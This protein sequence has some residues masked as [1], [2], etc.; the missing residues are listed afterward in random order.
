VVAVWASP[1]ASATRARESD[2]AANVV[3]A[4][5]LVGSITYLVIPTEYVVRDVIIYPGVEL[6]AIL[7]IFAGVRRYRPRAPQAW[8]LIA[9][10]FTAYWVGDVIWTVYELQDREPFPSP[11]DFFYLAGYPLIGA[12]LAIAVW[13]LRR[14]GLDPLGLLDAASLTV[15]AALLAWE[16]IIDP[17]LDDA[18]L[19]QFETVVTIAYPIGDLVLLALAARFVMGWRWNVRS[20]RLLVIG[21]V[22]TL[23]GDVLFTLDVLGGGYDVKVADTALLVGVVFVGS[24]ALDPTMRALAE[25]GKPARPN[26]MARLLFVVALA[27]VPGVVLLV[28]AVRGDPLYVGP[29]IVAMLAVTGITIARFSYTAGRER[30]AAAREALLSQYAAELLSASGRDDLLAVA[31]RTAQEL[32]HGGRATL[33]I[34]APGVPSDGEREFRFPVEVRG[35]TV[36]ELLAEDEVGRLDRLRDSLTT[37]AAQ[38]S[39]AL[40]RDRLLATEREAAEKLTEQNERLRELDRM[41]DRFVSSVT[42]ELRTPLTSMVGYLELVRDGEAGEL[43]DDQE[44]FL[45][46][47]DRNCHRLNDLI[48][49]I[50]LTARMDSGRFSLER[51]RVDLVALASA[52]VESM[53]AIAD[54]RD[55]D[56]QLYVADNPSPLWADPMRLGQMLDN[57]LSNA[58]KFTP[59][60]GQVIVAVATNGEGARVDVS[61]TGVGIPEDELDQLFQRFYRASTATAVKGTGLGLSITKT[62]VE[63]HG[64]TIAVQ[65][66][67]GVGTTFTVDLPVSAADETG[68]VAE[69]ATEVTR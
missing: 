54:N 34:P 8:L 39:L 50:L 18:E 2:H 3:L 26:D 40:E 21:L 35:E 37:V 64:G 4:V 23:V 36:A 13:R 52:Q 46:I 53:R 67:V 66:E 49:D 5:G 12:G 47:V 62:I 51:Q 48:D 1:D 55:V 11:A 68:E 17:V 24:A 6:I 65:S 32:L 38:L 10:G 69:P 45:E 7:A 29:T 31:E 16:Y 15:V 58:V 57:L 19:S 25:P 27:M 20:L 30:R 42:H 43:S 61:D 59:A 41:K 33:L 56:L 9:S 22:C 63:A 44:H 28:R 14:V 60:G